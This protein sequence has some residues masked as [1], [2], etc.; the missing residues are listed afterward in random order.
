MK[1]AMILMAACLVA[2]AAAAQDSPVDD[3]G[4]NW[5]LSLKGGAS[6][7]VGTPVG[8]GDLFDREKPL[9]NVS[10]GKWFTPYVGGRLAFQGLQ[11]KDANMVACNY[12]NL[13][14]VA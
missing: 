1:K 14:I 2:G 5:F 12:Q 3:W 4:T 13:E 9:L 11:L 8:H 7:F 6:A 10:A